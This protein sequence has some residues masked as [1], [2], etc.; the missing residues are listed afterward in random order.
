MIDDDFYRRYRRQIEAIYHHTEGHVDRTRIANELRRYM[1]EYGIDIKT[2]C[3]SIARK[4]AFYDEEEH[5]PRFVLDP[6]DPPPSFA[7]DALEADIFTSLLTRARHKTVAKYMKEL[8]YDEEI[9][10][11]HM[12]LFIRK[13]R[14][15]RDI[16]WA[17]LLIMEHW[18]NQR[19]TRPFD[20]S[21]LYFSRR[22][23]L[24]PPDQ[25]KR[26]NVTNSCRQSDT[27][28]TPPLLPSTSRHQ[29][30]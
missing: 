27:R 25:Q 24:W 6:G 26:Q 18:K 9:V 12:P 15:I 13:W 3:E 1:E 8:G 14:A 11:S 4:W 19:R 10:E 30:R 5:R 22:Y 16:E 23:N 21:C 17:N 29:Y 2:A 7:L 28:L 20:N